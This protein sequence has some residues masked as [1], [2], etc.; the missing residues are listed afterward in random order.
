MYNKTTHATLSQFV[1]ITQPFESLFVIIQKIALTLFNMIHFKN[2]ILFLFAALA[3]TVNIAQISHGGSPIN[4]DDS[5]YNPTFEFKSMP[6]VDVVAA[7]EEDD[8]ELVDAL[9]SSI[10]FISF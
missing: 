6:A 5:T 1:F 2:L 4:W 10:I 9:A 7:A 8:K 3:T